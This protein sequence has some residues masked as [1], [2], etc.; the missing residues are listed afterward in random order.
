M[1]GAGVAP[2][3]EPA[4][5][6]R[7]ARMADVRGIAELLDGYVA[8]GILL[9]KS[10]VQLYEDVQ[11]FRVAEADGRLVGC[12]ALHVLWEDLGELRTIAVDPPHAGAASAT[13]SW[14]S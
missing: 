11:D 7:R 1:S 2:A 9:G 8:D 14:T 10:L 3:P 5:T 6:V 12:G 4:A 13:G